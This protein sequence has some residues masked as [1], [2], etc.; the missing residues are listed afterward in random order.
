MS[1][2]A[3]FH[4]T[5]IKLPFELEKQKVLKKGKRKE[6]KEHRGLLTRCCDP[7]TL[8]TLVNSKSFGGP[9]RWDGGGQRRG[10]R[11]PRADPW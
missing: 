4:F 2:D 10:T 9:R 7:T 5:S 3:V 1:P 8:E 11:S 6:G